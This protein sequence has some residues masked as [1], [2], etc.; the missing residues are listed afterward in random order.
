MSSELETELASALTEIYAETGEA[1]TFTAP[2]GTETEV[3]GVVWSEARVDKTR[4]DDGELA[5]ATDIVYVLIASLAH[6][7]PGYTVTRT[8]ASETWEV[9]SARKE[10]NLEWRVEVKRA[11]SHERTSGNYRRPLR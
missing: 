10:R 9:I 6:V 8:G 4:N 11:Q 1:A 7:E 2:D 3:E 5:E